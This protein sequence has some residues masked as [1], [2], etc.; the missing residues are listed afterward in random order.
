M[1]IAAV[2]ALVPDRIAVSS[3]LGQLT[4][5]QLND[6][7]NQLARLLSDGGLEAGD[8]VALVCSNRN[9]F[10]IARF[11]CH[12]LGLRL[13]PVNW[14]LAS[15]EL[16]YIVDN[17][18]AKA[19][20]LESNISD[21]A[22][23]DMLAGNPS[24]L[25]KLAIGDAIEGFRAWHESLAQYSPADIDSPSLG[26]TMLYT[27]GTTGRPKGVLRKQADPKKAA[28]MQGLLTAVFQ[29]QPESG[30]DCALVTG[31]L[32]HAGPFNLCMTTPLTAG[33]AVVLMDKFDARD[34][35]ELIGRHQISHTFFV[36][37]MMSRLLNL[38]VSVKRATDI[39]SIRFVI[40]GAAPCPVSLK[41][42]MLA[43]F[44]PVL[45][46]MFAGTEGPG[47]L[48][49][50][51]EWLAK[52]GTVGKPGP[53]QIRV[54]D[55]DFC[56]LPVGAHGQ[57]YLANPP[58]SSFEYYRDEQKTATALRDGYYTAGDIGYLDEDGYLF[59]TGRSAEVIISGGVNI[60]PQEIDD[61]LELH[62]AIEDV[63]CVGVPNEDWGEEV[64][65]VLQ[66]AAGR[67]PSAELE[68]QILAFCTV[69]LASQK[70]PRSFDYVDVIPRS[71]AGKVARKSL[72]DSYWLGRDAVI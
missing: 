33:I 22:T 30:N 29:F 58:D 47:T 69:K 18:D 70:L 41:R 11:A 23:S 36:P 19:L 51:Q 16:G 10:L 26:H 31:P 17:C 60:Y 63:A 34:A 39:T 52:P 6:Y 32:Y 21:D 44:G 71:E 1:E 64:K 3:K 72:R 59:L 13:T 15:A 61:V 27:S 37:T 8:A 4:F 68:G 14:H 9:E 56:E 57:L 12:R 43:W 45:W 66:L 38:P 7:S 62:D 49:S 25:V 48:V 67:L 20:I 46:E 24:L 53:G 40:H 42:D 54:V 50:P 28:D 5:K 35:L 2:A 65:A 55:E